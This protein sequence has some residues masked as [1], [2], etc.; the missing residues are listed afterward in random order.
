MLNDTLDTAGSVPPF[1]GQPEANALAR[2]LNERHGTLGAHALLENMLCRTF[3]GRIA[4]VS[5]FGTESAVLLHLVARIDRATPVLFLDTGKL[6]AETLRYKD[7]LA[8][9]LGLT[10]IRVLRPKPSELRDDD[11][12]GTLW[13]FLP[14][15]CCHLRKVLPLAAGLR[16]FDAWI[17]GRKRFQ[18]STRAALPAIEPDA[19]GR[20]KINPLADWTQADI[21]AYFKAHDLPRHTLEADGYRSIGCAP[22]TDR[23]APGEDSRAGRWRHAAKTECG[24]HAPMVPIATCF[25]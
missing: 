23:V 8:E 19:D 13:K 22:C 21:A 24:I 11:R 12:D 18:G 14:D 16:G 15:H 2:H 10:D 4:L 9:R 5:S 20:I 17:T 7:M 25:G 1:A 3:L 6:F